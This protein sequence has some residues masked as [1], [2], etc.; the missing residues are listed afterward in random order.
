[1]GYQLWTSPITGYRRKGTRLSELRA[2]F[3]SGI[4]FHAIL[5]PLQSCPASAPAA[6][7]KRIL[8]DKGFDVAGVRN[9]EDGP[10]VGYVEREALADGIVRDHIR[11]ITAEHLL[12]D[13]TPL[14]SLL[15]VFKDR[16][17]AFVLVGPDVRGIVA[18]ADLN[19][20][21][22]RVY[23][24]GLI[25]L[26]EMHLGWWV[27]AT[28]GEDSW[29]QTIK[30]ARLDAAKE[31]QAELRLRS[32]DMPLVEC[33][34]FCDRRD[35]VLARGELRER[36]SVGQRA[37]AERLLKRS[38]RLRNDLAHSQGDLSQ[39]S[40]WREVIDLVEWVER[41]VH[42]SDQCVEE[43]AS[44]SARGGEERLWVSA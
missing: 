20:P 17:H 30:P 3:A 10:V 15:S 39:G 8:Q 41:L 34:Q 16:Q 19:K 37:P 43:D 27:K 36:L 11:P 29:Q 40:S 6:E 12:S 24:F 5:E 44:R 42:T 25:S 22:V 31:R 9:D 18:T 32:Q 35:L 23:L 14:V 26:L 33:L 13:S 7:V 38:E 21:P 28:Y 4:T 1:M 2:L